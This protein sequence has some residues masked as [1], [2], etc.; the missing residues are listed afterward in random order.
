MTVWNVTV[1]GLGI[2][3]DAKT[4]VRDGSVLMT[5]GFGASGMIS[6]AAYMPFH[7]YVSDLTYCPTLPPCL[8]FHEYLPAMLSAGGSM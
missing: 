5:M 8:C 7:C 4:V 3:R 1:N 2:T 6:Y